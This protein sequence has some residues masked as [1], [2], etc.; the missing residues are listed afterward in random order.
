[1]NEEIL[2]ELEEASLVWDSW[3][4]SGYNTSKSMEVDFEFYSVNKTKAFEFFNFLKENVDSEPKIYSRRTM[5]IFKGW[6]I[7]IRIERTWTWDDFKSVTIF[8]LMKAK[9]Y[10]SILEGY[11]ALIS[12]KN[13]KSIN[14]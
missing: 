12:E 13:K 9:E 5:L 6:C 10:N 11:G 4:K 3:L 1:M 8:L 2:Q 7:A 14:C